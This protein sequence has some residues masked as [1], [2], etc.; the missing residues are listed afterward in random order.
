MPRRTTLI[1]TAAAIL[2]L[3]AAAFTAGRTS[4]QPQTANAPRTE[5]RAA[6]TAIVELRQQELDRRHA[7]LGQG[8]VSRHEVFEA[9]CDL[10]RDRIRLAVISFDRQQALDDA[11][12]IIE[13]RQEA[14]DHLQ[15]QAERMIPADLAQARIDL[16]EAQIALQ[17]LMSK[18]GETLLAEAL[19]YR[20]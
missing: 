10:L 11:R 12:R 5:I 18:T 2:I 19:M 8:R 6:L 7:A 20:P 3:P 9:E 16:A 1:V 17:L 4:A 13:I 14:A 15:A